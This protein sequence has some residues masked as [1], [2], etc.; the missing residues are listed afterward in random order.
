[1]PEPQSKEPPQPG[2]TLPRGGS[3]PS[4]FSNNPVPN[5]RSPSGYGPSVGPLTQITSRS[6][7]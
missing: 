4:L 1:M 6:P 3:T 2:D 5:V 7:S